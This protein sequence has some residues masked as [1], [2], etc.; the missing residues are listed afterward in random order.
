MTP[1]T[2]ANEAIAD[3][4]TRDVSAPDGLQWSTIAEES[5]TTVIF[6]TVGDAFVGRYIG[7][8]HIEPDNGKDEPFDRFTFRAKDRELYAVN[9]SYKLADALKDVDPGTWVRITYV[10][11]ISTKRGLNPMKD[12]VIDVATN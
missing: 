1:K 2:K 7:I 9:Q 8:E 10:K 3:E 5:A 11:D 6:D 4:S 12:F